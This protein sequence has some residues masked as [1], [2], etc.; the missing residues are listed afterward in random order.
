MCLHFSH[1]KKPNP[2][3]WWAHIEYTPDGYHV[4]IYIRYTLCCLVKT[5][6]N[7]VGKIWRK[8]AW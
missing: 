7:P 6:K 4:S 1:V 2:K 5:P 3:V 8:S